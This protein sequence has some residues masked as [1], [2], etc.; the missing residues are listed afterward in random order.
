L[1]T[2]YP[3]AGAF[4]IV[5][6]QIQAIATSEDGRPRRYGRIRGVSTDDMQVSPSMR[7]AVAASEGRRDFERT[8]PFEATVAFGR[9]LEP[10]I[11]RLSVRAN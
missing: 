4:A 8:G 6:G 3:D 7:A 2:K 1:R 10:W 9:R 5:H 11:V